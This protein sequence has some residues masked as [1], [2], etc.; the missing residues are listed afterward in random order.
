[1]CVEQMLLALPCHHE[2]EDYLDVYMVAAGVDGE[3]GTPLFRPF[4]SAA[5]EAHDIPKPARNQQLSDELFKAGWRQ[6]SQVVRC[7]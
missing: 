7:N 3:K 5:A 6:R 1:M 4:V 2:L